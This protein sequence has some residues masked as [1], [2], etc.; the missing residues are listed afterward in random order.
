MRTTA[1]IVA[2][3]VFKS[4]DLEGVSGFDASR[5]LQPRDDVAILMRSQREHVE[6]DIFC[7]TDLAVAPNSYLPDEMV[8]K[9]DSFC[10]SKQVYK[11]PF[12]SP[13]TEKRASSA[14][15]LKKD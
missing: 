7:K 9:Y 5:R 6:S 14:T 1:K 2:F 15:P 4:W 12:L 13:H 3:C 10:G 11:Y 8:T